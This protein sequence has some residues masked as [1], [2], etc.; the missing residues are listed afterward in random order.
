MGKRIKVRVSL[1]VELDADVWALEYGIP[2]SEVREDVKGYAEHIV[3]EQI[4]MVTG[5]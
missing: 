2:L 3:R 1:T 5:E 4:A